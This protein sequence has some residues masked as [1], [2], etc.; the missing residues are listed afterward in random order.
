MR[1]AIWTARAR[2]CGSRSLLD[3]AGAGGTADGG[4]TAP[5]AE[6]HRGAEAERGGRA[7]GSVAGKSVDGWTRLRTAVFR[8]SRG[9]RMGVGVRKRASFQK[10]NGHM[11]EC[12]CPVVGPH[13]WEEHR[14]PAVP[15][16]HC[17]STQGRGKLPAE[18][19]ALHTGTMPCLTIDLSH[20]DASIAHSS[21]ST[22]LF[23][24]PARSDGGRWQLAQPRARFIARRPSRA[25]GVREQLS[26]LVI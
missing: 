1:T 17:V 22:L 23:M 16:S 3:G 5:S 21:S 26:G 8:G 15:A 2:K 7:C 4:C 24:L 25:C 13:T 10:N 19:R 9:E 12:P 11:V 20:R 18:P 6:R 14:S